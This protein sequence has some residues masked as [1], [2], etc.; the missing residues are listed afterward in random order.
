MKLDLD[1][2]TYE[3]GGRLKSERKREGKRGGSA[4]VP[5]MMSYST[6]SKL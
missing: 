5:L 2:A 6:K 1:L 3:H 4:Y